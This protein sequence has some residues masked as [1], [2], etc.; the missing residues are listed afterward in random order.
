MNRLVDGRRGFAAAMII[1]AVAGLAGSGPAAAAGAGAGAGTLTET[2]RLGDRR[3]VVTGDRTP[4][5]PLP[6]HDGPGQ[7]SSMTSPVS[8]SAAAPVLSACVCR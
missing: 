2:G 4:E 7:K 8:A 6:R 5:A 3:F 1:G